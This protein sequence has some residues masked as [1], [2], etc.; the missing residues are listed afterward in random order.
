MFLPIIPGIWE[1]E[2]A[3]NVLIPPRKIVIIMLPATHST[4][5]EAI[6]GILRKGIA[7]FLSTQFIIPQQVRTL[8]TLFNILYSSDA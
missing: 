4:V 7:P 6:E 3:N 5:T 2:D 1:E 8:F